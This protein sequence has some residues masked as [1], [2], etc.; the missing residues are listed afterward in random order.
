MSDQ[1]HW[2][3]RVG[4]GENFKNSS[5]FN[6]WGIKKKWM[7]YMKDIKKG[8]ILWFVV[9]KK[10]SGKNGLAIG[11]A[12]FNCFKER[13]IGPLIQISQT[14]EELGWKGDGEWEVEIHYKELYNIETCNILC[15]TR[16]PSSVIK[17]KQEDLIEEYK[18][19]KR[20]CKIKTN[21]Q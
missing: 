11:C 3:L 5:K 9:N 16:N 17:N 18:L 1:N 8:D 15:D 13:E 21:F 20:F 12:V 6:I 19:I 4:D 7:S 10:T 2:L 14:D